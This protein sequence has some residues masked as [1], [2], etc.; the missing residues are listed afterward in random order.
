MLYGN[1]IYSDKITIY[2]RNRCRFTPTIQP[3]YA[4]LNIGLTNREFG[5]EIREVLDLVELP[6][7]VRIGK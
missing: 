3:R 1:K 7:L 4:Q 2:C 5:I 6:L